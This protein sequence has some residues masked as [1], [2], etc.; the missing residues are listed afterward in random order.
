ML[1]YTSK[2]IKQFKA[3]LGINFKLSEEQTE[4]Q[5][6]F[7]FVGLPVERGSS[8]SITKHIFMHR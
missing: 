8:N 7:K 2:Q 1:A 4:R 3:V 5:K 6:T